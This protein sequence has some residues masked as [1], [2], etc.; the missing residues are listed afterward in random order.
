MSSLSS[1]GHSH[2]VVGVRGSAWR[3]DVTPW[4]DVRP[5][6][7][8]SPLNW[9]VAAD[10]RWY[11]PEHEPTTRQKW[12]AG[13]PVAETRVRVPT[14]DIVQRVW[15]TADL[16]GVVVVEFENESTLPVA[17][18]V[19]RDDL[20]TLRAVGGQRPQGIELPATSIVLPVAHGATTR[21]GL[22]H[23]TPRA[24]LFPDDVSSYA[25]VMRGWETACEVASQIRTPD[26]S[27]NSRIV[28]VRSALLLGE[29]RDN[30][31]ELMRLGESGP[32]LLGELVT[33]VE[34]RL[35]H[36]RRSRV[37]MWDTQHLLACAAHVC[38]RVGDDRAT[39]DIAR[40][41]LRLVD[42]P[43]AEIPSEV[44]DN[45]SVVAWTECAL[46]MP[47]PS[48]G[49][50]VVLP[51]GI[52]DPWRGANFECHRLVADPVRTLSYAVRW[53][54]P[55]PAVLWEVGG[56]PGLVV[57]GGRGNESWHSA[58]AS[59]DALFAPVSVAEDSRDR[60]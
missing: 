30:V 49:E 60:V 34:R 13:T 12:Y 15:C 44:P 53:H 14:G 50:C 24:G 31:I 6:D 29:G 41:W 20:L 54:G 8:S 46:A 47:S 39:D 21:V 1:G 52:P 40:A 57:R 59:G 18:A 56:A 7:G 5:H 33:V 26:D 37:L 25:S 27:L 10:D 2:R 23:S 3:A 48:G 19:T 32:D 16:G 55:R 4:G 22:L 58:D 35:K 36:E 11:V 45:D 17:V 42:R 38:A 28:A 51:R 43:V 9:R